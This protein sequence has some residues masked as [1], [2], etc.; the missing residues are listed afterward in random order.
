MRGLTREDA[1]NFYKAHYAPNNA[2]LVLAGD[3]SLEEA[4]TLVDATYAKVP[5]NPQIKPRVRPLEPPPAAERRVTL[6]DP[7][8]AQPSMSRTYLVPSYRTA[9][10]GEAEA[11]DLLAFLLGNGSSSHLFRTLVTEQGLATSAGAYYQGSSIDDTRF[12]VYATPRPNVTLP[13]LESAIDKAL[14][15]FLVKGIDEGE[16]RRAKTRFVAESIYS[17][18]SQQTLARM[19]GSARVTGSTIEDVR[20]WPKRIAAVTPEEIMAA[21]KAYLDRRRSVTGYLVREQKP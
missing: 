18:D 10:K 5:A 7:R 16:L 4:K 9:K 20:E 6:A 3:L 19:Y 2:I 17:Q 15:D 8:V 21:A 12:A 11:L 1:L 13:D 14:A